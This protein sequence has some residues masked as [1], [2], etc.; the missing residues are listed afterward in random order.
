MADAAELE[1]A[2]LERQPRCATLSTF[3]DRQQ[4]IL[5]QRVASCTGQALRLHCRFFSLRVSRRSVF[6]AFFGYGFDFSVV[7]Y[8]A[9]NFYNHVEARIRLDE[10]RATLEPRVRRKRDSYAVFASRTDP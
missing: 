10:D 1:R 4:S 6:S 7:C 3:C 5:C 2:A 8:L 9:F